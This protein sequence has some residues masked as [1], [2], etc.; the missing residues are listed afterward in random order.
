MG[1]GIYNTRNLVQKDQKPKNPKIEP[2]PKLKETHTHIHT[3]THVQWACKWIKNSMRAQSWRL[4]LPQWLWEWLRVTVSVTLSIC[5]SVC[6]C[7]W[8]SVC[9]CLVSQPSRSSGRRRSHHQRQLEILYALRLAVLC[10]GLAWSGSVS[11]KG[12]HKVC[13]L[14]FYKCPHTHTRTHMYLWACYA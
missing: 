5:V 12:T 11:A 3:L 1:I 4:R 13:S 8:V 14:W 10:S 6:V 2:K 7:V 9:L